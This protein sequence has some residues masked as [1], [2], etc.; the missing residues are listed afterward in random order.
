MKILMCNKFHFIHGGAERYLFDLSHGLQ[1]AGCEVMDFSMKDPRNLE[2]KYQEFFVEKSDFVNPLHGGFFSKVMAAANFIYSHEA[3]RKVESLIERY[4]PQIAH[5]HNI[6]H[7]VSPAI[8]EVFKKRKIPVVM[9]LHDYK[10][11]CPNYKLFVRGR[12]CAQCRGQKYFHCLFNRCIKDSL[13][14][15]FLGMVEAYTHAFL[16]SYVAVDL[17]IVPSRFTYEKMLESGVPRTKLILLPCVVDLSVFSRRYEVGKYLLYFGRLLV[18]KGLLTLLDSL[19]DLPDVHLKIIGD[20]PFLAELKGLLKKRGLSRV[21]VLGHCSREGLD[22]FLRDALCVILPSEWPEP[23]GLV[24][25]EAFAAGKC[26]I[27]SSVGGIPELVE[28]GV[29]GMLFEAGNPEDLG[30][31][32]KY[33]I[34]HP[35]QAR[36]W[37]ENGALKVLQQGDHKAHVAQVKE[38]YCRLL[39]SRPMPQE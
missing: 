26:V 20:G 27:A 39:S 32:I 19:K 24:I 15:S 10:I 33:V 37:G 28:D 8:L 5:V 13:P 22:K 18:E 6:Y 11:I 36:Q 31:K 4:R 7:Q 9:T 30:R 25:H 35:D 3:K 34:A 23:M 17:F 16:K 12:I 1:D 14:A 29:N 2:S 21:E 38:I